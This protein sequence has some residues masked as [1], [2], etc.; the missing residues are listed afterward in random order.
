MAKHFSFG[1]CGIRSFL[2]LWLLINQNNYNKKVLKQLLKEAKLLL[3]AENAEKLAK[4]WFEGGPLT[5]TTQ[6]MQNFVF[7]G[8]VFGTRESQVI[9]NRAQADNKMTFFIQRIFMPYRLLKLKYPSLNSHPY[10]LPIFWIIRWFE[11]LKSFKKIK[12]ALFEIHTNK[13]IASE[14]IIKTHKLF[15][16]LGLNK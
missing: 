4:C 3:F 10:L 8:G 7:A 1:G 11:L 16:D 6:E 5:P 13:S 2:D 15:S 9:I 14:N 12:G